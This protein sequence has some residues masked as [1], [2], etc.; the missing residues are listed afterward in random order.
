MRFRHYDS[1]KVFSVVAQNHSFSAAADVLNLTKGAVSYQIKQLED[2]LGFALFSRQPRGVVLTDHGREML[3]VAQ[4]A[5]EKVEQKIAVLRQ[6]R[7]RILTIGVSTY[8]ASRWLSPRLM[9]FMSSHPDIRLRL[10]PM[11]NLI[12]LQGEGVDLAIR[13]GRGQW[14]DMTVEPFLPCPAWPTGNRQSVELVGEIGLV[15]AFQQLTLLRDREDSDAWSEWFDVAELRFD[16]DSSTLIIPD[17][18]V[19]VQAVMDGQGIALNDMLVGPEIEAGH[20]F[21]LSDVALED[22]GYFLAYAQ[23]ALDN[24]DIAAFVDWLKNTD[25]TGLLS[26]GNH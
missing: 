21:R 2:D 23:G 24:P 22:Y 1:L 15:Q 26:S 10:Q 25:D 5:F 16:G 11:V 14:T 8:F 18:N 4:A 6:R 13:W 7:D 12:D 19:R 17:P 20:L 3:G 9:Q